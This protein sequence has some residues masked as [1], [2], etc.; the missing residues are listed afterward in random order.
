M[1]CNEVGQKDKFKQLKYLVINN[2]NNDDVD[3]RILK[4]MFKEQ[5]QMKSINCR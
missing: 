1:N 2:Q 5:S 3:A 4:A